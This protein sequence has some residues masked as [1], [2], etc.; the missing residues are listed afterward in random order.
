M[1]KSWRAT[2]CFAISDYTSKSDICRAK[3]HNAIFLAVSGY[4]FANPSWLAKI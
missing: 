1:L 2:L 4:D 3:R